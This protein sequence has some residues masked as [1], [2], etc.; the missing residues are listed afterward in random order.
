[1]LTMAEAFDE[2][3]FYKQYP[4]TPGPMQYS[5]T[6]HLSVSSDQIYDLYNP[7]DCEALADKVDQYLVKELTLRKK[8][9]KSNKA[10]NMKTMD[11]QAELVEFMHNNG[12]IFSFPRLPRGDEIE[13]EGAW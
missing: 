9:K 4:R 1:M 7:D 3:D 10:S 6:P 8:E 13:F 2:D 11:L 5:E 12:D